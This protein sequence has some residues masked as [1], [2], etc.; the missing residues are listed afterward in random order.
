[1]QLVSGKFFKAIASVFYLVGMI[2]TYKQVFVIFVWTFKLLQ[3]YESQLRTQM[4]VHHFLNVI[5]I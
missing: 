1:M 2:K 4:I 3:I 5:L